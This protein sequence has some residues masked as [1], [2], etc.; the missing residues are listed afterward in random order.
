MIHGQVGGDGPGEAG[1]GVAGL[2]GSVFFTHRAP[3]AL[4]PAGSRLPQFPLAGVLAAPA[5]DICLFIL[6]PETKPVQL[7]LVQQVLLFR[8]IVG[9]HWNKPVMP[10]LAF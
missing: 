1:I 2:C 10:I 7:C 9:P 3:W 6:V 5:T 8:E 4:S